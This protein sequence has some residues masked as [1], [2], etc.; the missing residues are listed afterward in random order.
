M[1][2]RI[3]VQRRSKLLGASL[4]ASL[5]VASSAARAEH[6]VFFYQLDSAR[7]V[8]NASGGAGCFEGF[9]AGLGGWTQA[10]GNPVASGGFVEFQDPGESVGVLRTSYDLL[11]EREDIQG[12]A[13]CDV[14]FGGGNAT[15]TTEWVNHVPNLPGDFYGHQFVYAIT[16]T[17]VESI[18]VSVIQLDATVAAEF[19]L[20]P[21]L[22][23]SQSKLLLDA[24]DPNDIV[25]ASAIEYQTAPITEAQL[26]GATGQRIYLRLFYD[27]VSSTVVASYSIDG[28]ATY[29][30]PFTS[31]SS[32]FAGLAPGRFWGTGA[33]TTSP[34]AAPSL[35]PLGG[36]L[37]ASLLLAASLGALR[38]TRLREAR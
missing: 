32:S 33:A 20:A 7:V 13:A 21:G 38:R 5:L 16:P 8:G 28:E 37:L 11:L 1:T 17:L 36:A 29:P 2:D 14:T 35:S 4:V 9:G 19:G 6:S 24:T 18:I 22:F 31:V 30:S 3:A 34:K 12:P 23:V 26:S 15:L 25:L 10:I 27:D